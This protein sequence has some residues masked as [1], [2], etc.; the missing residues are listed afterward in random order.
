MNWPLYVLLVDAG[1]RA[2]R[3]ADRVMRGRRRG[4][5][6]RES[7]LP[8]RGDRVPKVTEVV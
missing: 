5:T 6:V 8:K 2:S 3:I 7:V 1:W 4:M